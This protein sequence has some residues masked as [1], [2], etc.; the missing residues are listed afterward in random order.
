MGSLHVSPQQA[1]WQ[2]LSGST[3]ECTICSSCVGCG[4]PARPRSARR[5]PSA[6]LVQ[7]PL[8]ADEQ[9]PDLLNAAE[10]GHGIGEQLV[11]L[12]FVNSSCHDVVAAGRCRVQDTRGALVSWAADT[13][14]TSCL[15]VQ[16]EPGPEVGGRS[17]N[18]Y[19]SLNLSRLC[20]AFEDETPLQ[21]R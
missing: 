5:R 10:V 13:T 1:T 20:E 9:V 4:A 16:L 17:T 8:K 18:P 2:W 21:H 14:R 15:T 3:K 12:P 6:R 7:V 11:P 19:C